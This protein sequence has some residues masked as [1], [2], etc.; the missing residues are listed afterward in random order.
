MDTEV[1]SDLSFFERFLGIRVA[2]CIIIGIAIEKMFPAFT[3]TV[4]EWEYAK[5]SYEDRPFKQNFK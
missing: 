5:G 2:L 1:S 3:D 4:S